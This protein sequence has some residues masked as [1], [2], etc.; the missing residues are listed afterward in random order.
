MKRT[1]TIIAALLIAAGIAQASEVTLA[2]DHTDSESCFYVLETGASDNTFTDSVT[3]DALQH[4]YT[5]VPNNVWRYSRIKAVH[6]VGGDSEYSETLKWAAT[7][8]PDA[9]T[10]IRKMLQRIISWLRHGRGLRQV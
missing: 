4:T 2:W 3:V 10:G 9:P 7:V 1:S 8:K 6:P 5:N